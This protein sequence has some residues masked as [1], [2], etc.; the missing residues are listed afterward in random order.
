MRQINEKKK[1]ESIEFEVERWR[2]IKKKDREKCTT[3][4][5]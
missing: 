5:E 2:W 1:E 4:L 3:R